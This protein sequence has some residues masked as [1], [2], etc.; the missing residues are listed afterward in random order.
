MKTKKLLFITMI[1]LHFLMKAQTTYVPDDNFEQ[2][3]I[4][5]GYDSGA[6]DNYVPTANINTITSLDVT[7]KGIVDMT[8]VE[9]FTAL[10]SLFCSNNTITS[11]DVSQNTNLITLN[12]YLNGLTVL[13]VSQNLVLENLSCSYNQ[14]ISLN[15]SQNTALIN[16]GCVGNQLTSLDLSNNSALISILCSNNQLTDLNV[17]NGANINILNADFDATNNPNL[18]C[19]LVDNATWSTTNWAS[20]DAT[21]SF[22][23]VSCTPAGMTYV[24]DDNFEQAL[25]DL[26]YDSG[27][28]DNY[29]P[30][31]NINTIT[32]LDLSIKEIG[33]MTGIEDFTALQ[34][35][36]CNQN[37]ITSLDISSNTSLTQLRCFGN[38]L[39]ALD[40]SFNTLLTYIHCSNN[41]I[42]SFDISQN[43]DL[44]FLYIG[45]NQLTSL[46]ASANINLTLLTCFNNNITSL[47]FSQNTALVFL[48]CKSN[49]LSFLNVK[50]NNNNNFTYFDARLN[51][52]L[53][54]IL[55]DNPAWSATNWTLVDASTSF[56]VSCTPA[57]MT[58]VPDDNF[59][60]TLIDF[61]YDSGALDNYVPT[62][63]INTI[64]VLNINNKNIADLTGIEDFTALIHLGCYTNQLTSLDVTQNTSLTL[65]NASGNQL[66]T[67]DVSQNTALSTLNVGVNQLTSIDT[68][69]N[70]GLLYLLLGN[71]QLTSLDVS[72]NTAL[73]S[74][75]CS[76]NQLS[77]IDVSANTVLTNLSCPSNQIISL[78]VSQNT[79]LS[80]L[81]CSSNQLT[82]LDVKNGN[83]TNFT[84]FNA[85]SNPNL[86][87]ILVDDATW[88]TANWTSIDATASFN[89]VACVPLTYVPDDNFEQALI[90]L[91]YDSGALD[92]YVP[93]A[94]INTITNLSVGGK[95][96][97][98]LTGIEDFTAL[99]S[100]GCYSNQLTSL[101]VTQ[102]T[103]LTQLNASGNQLTTL[104]VSQNTA[105]LTLNVGVN[106]LTSIDTSQN[107]GLVYLLLGNNQLTSLD[108]S[109]NT[110]LVSLDCE[111]NQLTQLNVKNGN[112]I[113]LII[114]ALNN[115]NLTCILVDAAAWSTTNWT[116]IDATATFVNNQAECDALVG[117]EESLFNENILV[118]PNPT[119]D[120]IYINNNTNEEIIK[121]EIFNLLGK[122]IYHS[123]HIENININHLS[124]GI[125]TLKIASNIQNI[126]KK[127]IKQ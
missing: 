53:T 89:D 122:L 67:L 38:A 83:N 1:L 56:S 80:F 46:D 45:N 82:S 54:C 12:C 109:L 107:T 30:T 40:V 9:D 105:L 39:T 114:S 102:N 41:Q 21:T 15:L 88:S 87:C 97:V 108:V 104:D 62:A 85:A 68:S 71:N 100:L 13:D 48:S 101:D 37:V 96:I 74:L 10:T 42:S 112:N 94:N 127:I 113:N 73:V 61:G 52:N 106:Q 11:L 4:D 58:Y 50:N 19:I 29:V 72:L 25:I 121:V 98:D 79:A 2:A 8:G 57:G 5:L 33:D 120:Y 31:A 115:P 63:N 81:G 84:F 55:V 26:G 22:N 64:T 93:T 77:S 117:T 16:L 116:S 49:N 124:A 6:L 59:E 60:Q 44:E 17:K 69:Q 35:L 126:T 65:L 111:A 27:T 110:A 3:L 95:N 14:L 24:P 20:I 32:S 36:N 103:A 23:D 7:S 47:D 34:D 90:D 43:T 28:L 123:N 119:K 118:Y 99:T 70:A 86:M 66:T 125:Y 18:T 78:D 51:P 76:A 75:D 92:N 91:G